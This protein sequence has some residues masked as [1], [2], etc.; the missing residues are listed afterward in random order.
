M[1]QSKLTAQDPEYDSFT[2]LESENKESDNNSDS[3]SCSDY[4]SANRT[5]I[6]RGLHKLQPQLQENISNN[7]ILT[8]ASYYKNRYEKGLTSTDRDSEM[9]TLS[10]DHYSSSASVTPLA[11]ADSIASNYRKLLCDIRGVIKD[12]RENILKNKNYLFE[13]ETGGLSDSSI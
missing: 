6:N 4:Y 11:E 12:Q 10:S 5:S 8:S 7:K 2:S 3:S 1:S 13:N 9:F